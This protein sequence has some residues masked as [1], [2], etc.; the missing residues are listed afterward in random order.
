MDRLAADRVS[1]RDHSELR[2]RARRAIGILLEFQEIALN[3]LNAGPA[4]GGLRG[5]AG[6]RGLGFEDGGFGAKDFSIGDI[7]FDVFA[8]QSEATAE[9]CF[10]V[11]DG[12]QAVKLAPRDRR[13]IVV[14]VDD[15]ALAVGAKVGRFGKTSACVARKLGI[16]RFRSNGLSDGLA[17]GA[18]AREL[19]RFPHKGFVHDLTKIKGWSI[20]RE[21]ESYSCESRSET[22][23]MVLSN[24]RGALNP[25][26]T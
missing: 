5:A 21:R 13:R 23:C 20:R 17:D 19:I 22:P 10:R 1:R 7:E 14:K 15:V 8:F 6:L 16:Q 2:C 12:D 3:L 25:T 11:L 24:S 9:R 18:A 4:V 26:D